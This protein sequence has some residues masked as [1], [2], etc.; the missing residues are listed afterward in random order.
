MAEAFV[1][2][3]A[4]RR[5]T[6]A[7]DAL[8]AAL[9]PGQ[10][11]Q[12][13][14]VL[15]LLESRPVNLLLTGRAVRFSAL[16][17]AARERY[18]LAWGT[19]RLALRR[20]AFQAFR[21]LLSFLA[22]GDPGP[23]GAPDLRLSAIGYVQDD[24][25]LT[26]EPTP[27]RPVVLP[28]NGDDPTIPLVLEA[29]VAIVGSGAG[30]GVVARALAEAG[31]SVVVLEA[32]PFVAEPDMPRSELDAFDRLYLD[33]G[34]AASWDGAVSILAGAGVGGGTT[35]N[36]MTAIAA[37]DPV[38]AGWARAHG[39]AGFDGPEGDA[40]FAAVARELSV[41]VASHT[42][43]KDAVL[44]RGGAALGLE[45]GSVQRSANSCEQCGSCP[46][47]CRAGTKQS[48][49]RAHLADAYRA[50]ARIVPD[51][52]VER[53]LVESGR[54]AGVEATVGWEPRSA[55][56]VASGVAPVERRSI[57][58]RA[59]Q[60]VVAAGALRTPVVLERS[61]L[62]HPAIGRYLLVHPV[63]VVAGLLD[64]PVDMWRGTMQA[65]RS[66]AFVNGVR[67]RNGYAIESAPGHPGLVAL[68]LPWQGTQDHAD[69][70]ARLR[71]I[72]PLIAV[73]RD[74]GQGRVRATRSGGAR[75]DYRVDRVGMTTLRHGLVTMARIVRAAGARQMVA[76]GTPGEW[77]DVGGFAPGGEARAF[78]AFEGRLQRFDF[79][80]NRGTVFSAHQMGTAR[81]GADP[82]SHA[83]DP[84][85]RVRSG[86]GPG[87]RDAVVPGLYVADGS[88]FPTGLGVNPMLTVMALA[89]RVARTVLA[90]G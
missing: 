52:R 77:H 49:L 10:V 45:V 75:I 27:I 31:R 26:A 56:A 68:A 23:A 32:G 50:G 65:A 41:T 84:A 15:R 63:S 3:D 12:L 46:F 21:R 35:V 80:P 58:V 51:T 89:R 57:V 53:I 48:G 76:L 24:P 8:E 43:P 13:R 17:P 14:L 16:D 62:R 22:Y 79:G 88:L 39:L 4:Q 71:F 37:P 38:R 83:C 78:A 70:M 64:E 66:L 1:Q 74:G 69:L 2:G 82:R 34:L 60:V 18:L 86:P 85:G 5:A 33:H 42:P 29:D 59:R 81:L 72:A 47:G 9:D 67:G 6:V 36:W 11:G 87:G 61:G 20:S 54:A 55:R 44:L 90:E 19:S 30:G 73:T 28:P 40:D 25:G 7:V